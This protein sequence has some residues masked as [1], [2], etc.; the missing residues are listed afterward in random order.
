MDED[1]ARKAGL[2]LGF[3][4]TPTL[5]PSQANTSQF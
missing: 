1:E 5:F 3:T 4:P 2:P